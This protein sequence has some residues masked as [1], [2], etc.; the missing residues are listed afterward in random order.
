MK[1]EDKQRFK[2]GFLFGAWLNDDELIAFAKV[3]IPLAVIGGI[4][5]AGIFIITAF[6]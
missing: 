5:I 4:I 1:D 2:N 3:V 6:K